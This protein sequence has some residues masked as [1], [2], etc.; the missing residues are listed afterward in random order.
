MHVAT[1]YLDAESRVPMSCRNY[2]NQTIQVCTPEDSVRDFA[3]EMRRKPIPLLFVVSPDEVLEGIVTRQAL[4]SASWLHP[5]LLIRDIM[6]TVLVYLH[7]DESPD[8]AAYHL[9]WSGAPVVVIEEDNQVIGWIS[10]H[11][12]AP[13][14]RLGPLG[15][16][17]F[18]NKAETKILPLPSAAERY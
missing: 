2:M 10:P 4:L 5:E 7:P 1:S 17:A 3:E 15:A 8:E 16:R 13:L 6:S 18:P 14:A 9:V 11:D 12:L